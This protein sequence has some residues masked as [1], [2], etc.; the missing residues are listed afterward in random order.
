MEV[1]INGFKRGEKCN[2]CEQEF[3]E[4]SKIC[5]GTDASCVNFEE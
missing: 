4:L 3:P 1:L 2:K 5:D